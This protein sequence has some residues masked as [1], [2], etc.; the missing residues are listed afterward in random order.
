[1]M[2]IWKK[3]S[4]K[5][6][7]IIVLR[8]KMLPET[9]VFI[10]SSE[11]CGRFR[12]SDSVLIIGP[13]RVINSVIKIARSF[14]FLKRIT[15]VDNEHLAGNVGRFVRSQEGDELGHFGRCSGS[16]HRGV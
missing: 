9:I 12:S 8:F 4:K 14:V 1:M 11:N 15:A 5:I 2:V 7:R 16:F 13:Q 6:S 10:L 3:T